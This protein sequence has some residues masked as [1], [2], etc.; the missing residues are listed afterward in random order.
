MPGVSRCALQWRIWSVVFADVFGQTEYG[1]L[2]INYGASD[3]A[4]PMLTRLAPSLAGA[5]YCVQEPAKARA[6][7]SLNMCGELRIRTARK[8]P[9]TTTIQGIGDV[10]CRELAYGIPYPC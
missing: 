10:A 1:G 9:I 4:H 8:H 5:I 2:A 3:G 7:L 6:G